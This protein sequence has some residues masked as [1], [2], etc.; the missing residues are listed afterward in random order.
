LSIIAVLDVGT[1]SVKISIA[2][3][4]DGCSVE[5]IGDESAI[6]R[7]G[8][9]V[10]QTGTL[11]PDAM[12][13][14]LL[15]LTGFVANLRSSYP[16][17]ALT[18]VGTSAMRDASNG[19]EFIEA[20]RAQT[21]VSI[22]IIGGDREA[23]LAYKAVMSDPSFRP[24]D[25]APVVI[26]DIGGG[27]TEVNIVRSGSV[28]YHHSFNIGAV[29]LTERAAFSDP[30]T[31]AQLSAAKEIADGIFR[32]IPDMGGAVVHAVGIGGTVSNTTRVAMQG[33][34]DIH[35]V[36]LTLPGV[37]KTRSYLASLPLAERRCV[38]GLDP[39]RADVIV[40]GATVLLSV[41]ER[42]GAKGVKV[43]LRGLRYGLL[44]ELAASSAGKTAN[45]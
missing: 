5:L 44:S 32:E 23:N 2:K 39:A 8:Q 25:G 29:R 20:V 28:D 37:E 42:V 40:A 31:S 11:N 9:G 13:R 33:V 10:D 17:A 21:G 14:T 16:D 30:P 36:F 6:T 45:C 27:S 43:S 12:E 19:A 24:N 35:G 7:L 1:N 34:L 4:D 38:P 3:S 26:F 18:A 15:A 41:M 22:E